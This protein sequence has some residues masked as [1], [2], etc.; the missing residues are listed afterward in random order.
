MKWLLA[1]IKSTFLCVWEEKRNKHYTAAHENK[2][3][4]QLKGQRKGVCL[5]T[6]SKTNLE[7]YTDMLTQCVMTLY[8]SVTVSMCWFVRWD[9]RKEN[10]LCSHCCMVESLASALYDWVCLRL[11]L[12]LTS[13]CQMRQTPP[14]SAS[15]PSFTH[16]RTI[17]GVFPSPF[18]LLLSLDLLLSLSLLSLCFVHQSRSPAMQ[19]THSIGPPLCR[20]L[21]VPPPPQSCPFRL[22]M[23]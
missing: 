1:V 11:L 15:S 22:K 19:M 14:P 9:T 21:M 2:E 17:N 12:S 20:G 3:W 6:K 13:S 10:K 8:V 23:N 7:M 5:C 18:T 16:K 4:L